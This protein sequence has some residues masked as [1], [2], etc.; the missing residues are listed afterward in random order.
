VLDRLTSDVVLALRGIRAAPAIPFAAVLT[1]SLAVGINLAMAG[2]IDRAL[3]SPPAHVVHPEQVFTVGFEVRSPS[4]QRDIASTASYL[5]YEALQS[6]IANIPVAAWHYVSMNIAVGT[7]R[8]QVK[9]NGVTGT[10][11]TMLGAHAAMGRVVLPDDDRPPVGAPVAVISHSL[12]RSAFAGDPHVIGRQIRFGALSVEVVGVMPAGFSGHTAERV[13]LWLPLSTS[14]HD[15][16]NWHREPRM[17]VVELGV[18]SVD[19]RNRESVSTQLTAATRTP[20]V[21]APIVGADIAPE[22]Y[23]IAMW[24]GALSLV[25]LAAGLANGATLFLV[26]NAR[27]RR[28]IHIR[29]ALG[30]TRARLLRQLIVESAVVAIGATGAALLLAFW[31]DELVRRVLFPTLVERAGSNPIV[32]LAALVGGVCTLVVGL[33]SSALQLPAQVSAE[34]LAGRR[35]LW[36]RSTIQRELLI[37]QSTLAVVLMTGAGM[38]AQSYLRT[39]SERHESR[40]SDVLMVT[41]D[42]G[43]GAVRDQDQLLAAALDRVRK[44]QGVDAATP[45]WVLPFGRGMHR[46]RLTVP[47]VGEPR[48]GD[49]LASMIASTR[50]LFDILRIDIVEGRGFTAQDDR[51][52]PVVVVSESLARAIWPGRTAVGKCI[53]VGEDPEPAPGPSRRRASAPCRE[54][55]GI[56]RDWRAPRAGQRRDMYY[57]VPV[58]QALGVLPGRPPIEGVVIRAR[59]DVQLSA[60]DLRLAVTD[61][62]SDLPFVRVESYSAL[63]APRL[64][65]W[66]IGMRLLAIFGALALAT[67]V[68][69]LY[70]A[71][72]HAVAERRQEIAVRIAVGA[73][74][75]N[76]LLMI[77]REGTA[78]AG[79]G[80]I[81]GV[82]AATLIG[83]AAR[84]MIVGL[85][86][87]GPIVSALAVSIV[88]A[89]AVAATWLPARAASMA[90]PGQALRV[91]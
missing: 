86:S 40:L 41:F 65:H 3:L 89:G 37:V 36:R 35:R 90:D 14:M 51:G 48:L 42:D 10:Y 69:G 57:Y 13:D 67:A 76:I 83:W 1:T 26:R 62:R 21:L 34:D 32:I 19:G 47:G 75:Q 80:A 22:P 33:V 64:A 17:A 9:V 72:A 50:E 12:W 45:F 58:A 6:R 23:R 78:L 71:F 91:D 29:A 39:L 85:S 20:I 27:R 15:T 74:R 77:L 53:W 88:V 73:S 70:A 82:I 79:R 31:F 38:F 28:E 56:A 61:G 49:Q 54:V 18:R 46:P 43:P 68:L 16:P 87:P 55:V 5:T 63:E 4:G 84:S 59:T 24:L 44:V 25:V 11:F 60:D 81:N 8:V 52:A 66:V 7:S 2:L 30:A